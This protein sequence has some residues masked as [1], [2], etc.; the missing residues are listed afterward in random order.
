MARHLFFS[1]DTPVV[2]E[3]KFPPNVFH[4]NVD[5]DIL[6]DLVPRVE[7]G[8]RGGTADARGTDK[9]PK[10]QEES[11]RPSL[12]RVWGDVACA[13]LFL[14]PHLPGCINYVDT[15]RCM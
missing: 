6:N 13:K 12:V 3:S 1:C 4:S 7:R 2:A 10:R 15:A 9:T 5:F 11:V 14:L 8:T